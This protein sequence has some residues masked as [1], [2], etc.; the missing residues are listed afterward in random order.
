MQYTTS[1]TVERHLDD[2]PVTFEPVQ[3]IDPVLMVDGDEHTLA[4]AAYDTDPSDYEWGEVKFWQAS[5]RYTSPNTREEVEG[6]E[7]VFLVERYEHGA[8]VYGL[9]GESSAVDRQ[10]DVAPAGLIGL[11]ADF[12]DPEGAAR[13]Y[14]NEYTSWCNGVVYL[15]VRETYVVTTNVQGARMV[16]H[17][18]YDCVG[19]FIGTEWAKQALKNGEF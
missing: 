3:H 11:P 19:G 6:C 1:T 12:A 7:H 18:D 13:G 5:H 16:E 10:W 8:V 9:G 14:L 4:Y 15:L 17:V 2:Y